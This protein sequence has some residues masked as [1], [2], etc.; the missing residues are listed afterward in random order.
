M[1]NMDNLLRLS[2]YEEGIDMGGGSFLSGH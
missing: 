1:D 2:R